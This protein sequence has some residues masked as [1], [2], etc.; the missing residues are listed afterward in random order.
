MYVFVS[1]NK[2]QHKTI[3]SHCKSVTLPACNY[4]CQ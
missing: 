4:C 2:N 1:P 3:V